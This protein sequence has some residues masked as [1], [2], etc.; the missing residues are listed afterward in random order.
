MGYFAGLTV[1]STMAYG[2][3]VSSMVRESSQLQMA[4]VREEF[5]RKAQ[6]L[7][8]FDDH[9]FNPGHNN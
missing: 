3:I 1:A 4:K 2:L 5:G 8:G 9:N 7:H 6:E